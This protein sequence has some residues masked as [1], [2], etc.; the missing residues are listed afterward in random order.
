MLEVNVEQ[1]E[2]LHN[3]QNDYSLLARL[4]FKKTRCS[5]IGKYYGHVLVVK[6]LL[7]E[8]VPD[9]LMFRTT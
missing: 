9:S 7:K 5:I 2:K 1:P 6:K 4:G 3:S 8:L